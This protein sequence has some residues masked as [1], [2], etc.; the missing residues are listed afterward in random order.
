MLSEDEEYYSSSEN[1]LSK[2]EVDGLWDRFKES[3]VFF[4]FSNRLKT[5]RKRLAERRKKGARRRG[6]VME[7]LLQGRK[8]SQEKVDGGLPW[9]SSG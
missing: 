2:A 3:C 9:R 4:F 5:E 6:R 1:L 7:G 8:D